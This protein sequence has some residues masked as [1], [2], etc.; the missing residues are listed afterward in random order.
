[1]DRPEK[2]MDDYIST[3]F[4]KNEEFGQYV[5]TLSPKPRNGCRKKENSAI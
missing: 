1:V 4:E 2:S 3:I 5:C